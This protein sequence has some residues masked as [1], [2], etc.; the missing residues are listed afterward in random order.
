MQDS[1]YRTKYKVERV[2][3]TAGD[4]KSDAD[5]SSTRVFFYVETDIDETTHRVQSTVSNIFRLHMFSEMIE[6]NTSFAENVRCR[7]PV[8][9]RNKTDLT[10]D[11]RDI[12][13]GGVD[14][15]RA[16]GA[17]QTM[18]LRN[19]VNVEQYRQQQKL[20]SLLNSSRVDTSSDAWQSRV[21][22]VTG[23]PV[24]DAGAPD[25]YVP[26]LV[27]LPMD[28]E[29]VRV[30]LP[31]SRS[32]LVDIQ[33]HVVQQTCVAMGVP[34]LALQGGSGGSNATSGNVQLTDNLINFTLMRLRLCLSKVLT[35][36]YKLCHAKLN[37]AADPSDPSSKRPRISGDAQIGVMFPALQRPDTV[38]TLHSEGTLTYEA[39]KKFLCTAF[40]FTTADFEPVQQLPGQHLGEAQNETG[41]QTPMQAGDAGI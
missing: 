33:K 38:R 25:V 40:E 6:R 5:T 24:F 32:D 41:R 27:P 8:V 12:A 13:S 11:E 22:P 26:D 2:K 1:H 21:D 36:V 17:S 30:E 10:F 15:L 18:Q 9:T 3:L 37:P 39:Y 20:A 29:P 7:P 34:P 14:G 31:Q 35:D 16:H 4:S 28:A 19:R 23:L